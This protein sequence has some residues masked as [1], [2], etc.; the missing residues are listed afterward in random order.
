[1]KTRLTLAGLL[2]L[3]L[4]LAVLLGGCRKEPAP[5]PGDPTSKPPPKAAADAKPLTICWA[6]WAPADGLQE[7]GNE[8]QKETG[9]AVKVRQIPWSD[10]QTQVFLEFGQKQTDFDLVV[11]DSQWIGRGATKGFYV[12]LTDWLPTAVDLK[13]LS[14][15]ALKYLC[16]YPPGSGRYYA[17]PCET[18]AVGFAYRKDWFEDAAEKAAFK[19][20]FGYDLAIPK[21]WK[22]FRDVAAFFHRPD[23][24]RYGCALLT[25]RGYD[26]LIMGF[27]HFLWCFGGTWGDAAG[28]KAEGFVNNAGAVEGLT[29]MVELLKYAPPGAENYDYGKTPEVLENGSTA[30]IMDYFAFFPGL[31]GKMG[32]KVGFFRSPSLTDDKPPLISLGGQGISISAK[33]SPERQALAKKFVA[34]F[35]Q[36]KVQKQWITKP[37]GFTANAAILNSPDFRQASPYNAPFADSLEYLQDFWNVPQYNE[38]LAAAQRLVGEAVDGKLTPKAALDAL[39][40]EHE[41]IFREAGLLK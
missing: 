38:L 34:W 6:Q 11:G 25:G 1:M 19:A 37:A 33:V 4:G 9:I 27:Q 3:A 2:G 28:Y 40:K 12:D 32:D 36:E 22:Q 39:A 8:F 35:L 29:F 15:R 20:K 16:E 31:A 14:P 13:T 21:T 17:A 41:A 23:Q 30:M 24:K 7:L 5:A 18:D 26:S 10:F